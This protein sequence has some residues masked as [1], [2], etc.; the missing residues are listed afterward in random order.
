MNLIR[1]LQLRI[2]WW[3]LEKKLRKAGKHSATIRW[4][5]KFYLKEA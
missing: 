1:K 4:L 3:R 2:C 5:Q